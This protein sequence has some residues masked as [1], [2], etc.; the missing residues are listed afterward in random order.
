MQLIVRPPSDVF[1]GALSQHP[2]RE[3]IDPG[4]AAVQHERF[5]AA[6]EAAG[7]AVVPMPPEPDLPDAP[8][9]SDTIVALPRADDP[10][11]PTAVLVETRPAEPSRRPEVRSVV[12]HA[13]SL[14][15]HR[16][17]VVRVEPPATLE[18]GDVI[19]LGD[20]ILIGLSA[21]TNA[22][23]AACLADAAAVFGYRPVLCPVA[24]RLHLA[25]ALTAVGSDVL[26]GTTAGY[27]SLDAARSPEPLL[28]DARR[29]LIP[30]EEL[31]GANVLAIGARCVIASGNPIAARTL[32]EVGLTVVEVELDAFTRADG[33]PTCLVAIVP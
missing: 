27:A 2:E 19:V 33:G 22:A 4:R 16:L 29:L 9:V 12:D 17:S 8:F 21:R 11:G 13:R 23:G 10:D 14:V 26:I 30:D 18:G 28:A 7:A 24:D 6:L 25:T 5:V 15:G 20:R 1:R 3:Q 31:P 32:A